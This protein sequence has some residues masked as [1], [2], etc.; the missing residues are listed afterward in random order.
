MMFTERL[1]QPPDFCVHQI[2][3]YNQRNKK[4]SYEMRLEKYKFVWL[5]TWELWEG[6]DWLW[7]SKPGWCPTGHRRG[8]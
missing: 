7:W 6:R 2:F 8:R 1:V 3:L 5:Y 4:E